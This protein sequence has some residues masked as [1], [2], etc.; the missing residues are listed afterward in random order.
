VAGRSAID[1]A[2]PFA[3]APFLIKDVAVT[4]VAGAAKRAAAWAQAMSPPTRT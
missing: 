4:M 1:H 2:A 3:G